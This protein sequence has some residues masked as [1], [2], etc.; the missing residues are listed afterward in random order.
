MMDLRQLGILIWRAGQVAL[1]L[2]GCAVGIAL[3]VLL[4]F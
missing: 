2:F 3:F 4:T 1:F